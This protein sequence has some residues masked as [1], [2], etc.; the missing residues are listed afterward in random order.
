MFQL[1]LT[2]QMTK[3]TMK[4]AVQNKQYL[5]ISAAMR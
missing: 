3:Y 4:D 5:N 2:S 1:P